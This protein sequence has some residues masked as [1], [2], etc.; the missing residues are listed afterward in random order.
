[1]NIS[2]LGMNTILQY[3]GRAGRLLQ[4]L[5]QVGVLPWLSKQLRNLHFTLQ[6]F[7]LY[8]QSMHLQPY[9]VDSMWTKL[10]SVHSELIHI[11]KIGL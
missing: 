7:L 4:N 3:D 1:M 2:L 5:T 11:L 6:I 10:T 9:K 8:T